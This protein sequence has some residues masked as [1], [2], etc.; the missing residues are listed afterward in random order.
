MIDAVVPL[1]V[2]VTPSPIKFIKPNAPNVE[3]SSA[4]NDAVTAIVLVTP[5]VPLTPEVPDVP[6]TPLTLL[7]LMIY[8]VLGSLVPNEL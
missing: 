2:A 3:P 6:F 1:N 5:D 4:T 7:P 8:N